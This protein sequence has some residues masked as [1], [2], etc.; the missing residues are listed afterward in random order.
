MYK[1]SINWFRN[2]QYT[3]RSLTITLIKY[4]GER[5]IIFIILKSWNPFSSQ[6]YYYKIIHVQDAQDATE[7]AGESLN[8]EPNSESYDPSQENEIV[9]QEPAQGWKTFYITKFSNLGDCRLSKTT[10]PLILL[11]I[12]H[13]FMLFFFL[14]S[15][16]LNLFNKPYRP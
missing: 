7:I 13:S 1:P 11:P 6:C 10:F 12:W 4:W 5:F 9:E 15:Q 3:A 16:Y 8:D 14:I 2:N